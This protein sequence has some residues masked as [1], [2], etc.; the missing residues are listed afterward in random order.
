MVLATV[1]RRRHRPAVERQRLEGLRASLELVT[2]AWRPRDYSPYPCAT[3][4]EW[5]AYTAA[6]PEPT[7]DPNLTR[8]ACRDCPLEYQ[9][10]ME[11]EGRCWPADY[12]LTP[13]GR[14]RP[15][16]VQ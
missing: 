5:R 9:A 10:A 16:R 15:R 6:R 8:E 12:A 11:A 14:Q 13:R 1:P 4:E 2:P 3:D 7:E